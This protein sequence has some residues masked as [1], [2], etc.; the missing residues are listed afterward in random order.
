MS[1]YTAARSILCTA[2]LAMPWSA[3]AQPNYGLQFNGTN[4]YV[5][6]GNDVASGIRSVELWFRPSVDITPNTSM[7]GVG[8]LIR[9]DAFQT[10]EFGFYF[11]GTEWPTGRGYLYFYMRD[12]GVLHEIASDEYLWSA[13]AWHHVCATIDANQGMK[14]YVDGVLQT[15]TDPSST[16]AIPS[17]A[18]T[19]AVGTWGDALIRYFPGTID[20]VRMWNRSLS[21]AEVQDNMC[22]AL[23]PPVNGL[24]GYWPLDEGSGTTAFD[25][26]VGAHDGAVN[27]A[28]YVPLNNC[29][30]Y[31]AIEEPPV[32][33]GVTIL[34]NP[35]SEGC[36]LTMERPVKDAALTIIDALGAVVFRQQG[37]SGSR[38][39]LSRGGLADGTYT[40]VLAEA[41]GALIQRLPLVITAA[42]GR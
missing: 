40:V 10:H 24:V 17:S 34:P 22:W 36:A 42:S 8:L 20:E 11:R 9:N 25:A 32:T 27:G 33:G 31:V 28:T 4:S 5:D 3:F 37:L 15:T 39:E 6:L 41:S 1:L 16:A 14:L 26:T 12:N 19:T 18:E 38:F 2:I 7:G 23:E 21:A 13:D 35:C 29:V 30:A